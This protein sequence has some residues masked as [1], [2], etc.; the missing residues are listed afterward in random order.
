MESRT[1]DPQLVLASASPRRRD[2]LAQYGFRA[3]VAPAAITESNAAW[4][5]VREL[6]SLNAV[7][8]A[9]FASLAYPDSVVLGVDT[10]VSLNDRPLGKPVDMAEA[11]AMLTSLSGRSHEVYSGVCLTRLQ[12]SRRE[13]FVTVTQVN[14]RA[15]SAGDIAAYL[16]S[17]DPL[18][19]AGGYAAQDNGHRIIASTQGSWTNVMGLPME[20]LIDALQRQFG[21]QPELPPPRETLRPADGLPVI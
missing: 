3:R 16:A 15:L 1:I 12:P 9:A 19:K 20:D 6:V 13:S 14:F 4:L 17:I 7:R 5:T 2:L 11:T 21:I 8:K 10:L 18:D